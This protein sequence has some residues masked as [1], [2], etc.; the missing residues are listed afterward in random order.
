MTGAY[1]LLTGWAG[2]GVGTP[3]MVEVVVASRSLIKLR[4]KK[5]LFPV[6]F[7]GPPPRSIVEFAIA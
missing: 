7:S 6:L 5:Q 4:G 2:A 3:E 1:W